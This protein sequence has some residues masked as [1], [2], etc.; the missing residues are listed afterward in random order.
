MA[1][2]TLCVLTM[3]A[4]A[5]QADPA[6]SA[7]LPAIATT[8]PGAVL[9]ALTSVRIE[10]LETMNSATSRIGAY[11]PIRLA[12]PIGLPDGGQIPAGVSGMGQVVHAA[13]SRFGGKPGELI[14]AVRYLDH[15]GV[16]IPLRSLTFGAARGSDRT[17]TAAAVGIA[18]GAAG[19]M[20]GMF[21]TG[22]EVNVP[23]GTLARAKTSA[24][25]LFAAAAATTSVPFPE[26]GESTK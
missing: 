18:G 26:A 7:P 22:G 17:N 12:D 15:N 1:C 14:L 2:A 6:A 16:R 23:A 21:I 5:A 3:L 4:V 13:K 20:L 25:V 8:S 9:P 19:A 10:I 24:P 11:F